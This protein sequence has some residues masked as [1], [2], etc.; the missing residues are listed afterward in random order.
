MPAATRAQGH[1]C[2]CG[3]RSRRVYGA[4]DG[5]HARAGAG[6]SPYKGQGARPCPHIRRHVEEPAPPPPPPPRLRVR[7]TRVCAKHACAHVY[8]YI[9]VFIYIHPFPCLRVSH[10]DAEVSADGHP[11]PR[12]RA[13]CAPRG[14]RGPPTAHTHTH[15]HVCPCTHTPA[16]A[17]P[18]MQVHSP[19]P[20]LR[21]H[22]HTRACPTRVHAPPHPLAPSTHTGG[23]WGV[24]PPPRPPKP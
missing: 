5:L 7:Q 12:V 10:T 9:F 17:C 3:Y 2:A 20:Q 21:T 24:P 1:A 15:T 11:P 6:Q 19:R 23:C 4:G 14:A 8:I 22:G 16:H 13:P 18:R